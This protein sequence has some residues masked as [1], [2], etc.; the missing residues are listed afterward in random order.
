MKG[1]AATA[2]GTVYVAGTERYAPQYSPIGRAEAIGVTVVGGLIATSAAWY[3]YEKWGEQVV[4]EIAGD[5]SSDEQVHWSITSIGTTTMTTAKL[6]TEEAS[7]QLKQIKNGLYGDAKSVIIQHLNDGSSQ[8]AAVSAAQDK[9]YEHTESVERSLLENFRVLG[10]QLQTMHK[11]AV[12]AGLAGNSDGGSVD[13]RHNPDWLGYTGGTTIFQG[14][15]VASYKYTTG[16]GKEYE[17]IDLDLYISNAGDVTKTGSLLRDGGI[18]D[19]LHLKDPEGN[20][21]TW[22]HPGMEDVLSS[23]RTKRDEVLSQVATIANEI[24]SNYQ[25]GELDSVDSTYD[26]IRR[27]LNE[28]A[29]DGAAAYATA[30]EL[31]YQTNAEADYRIEY[32]ERDSSGNLSDPVTWDGVLLADT[33]TFS[34]PIKAGAT[35]DTQDLSGNVYFLFNTGSSNKTQKEQL[36][37]RFTVKQIVGDNGEQLEQVKQQNNN[38]TTRDTSNMDKQLEIINERRDA[39]DNRNSLPTNL[40]AEDGLFGGGTGLP[41]FGDIPRWV[42]AI[43]VIGGILGLFAVIA[44]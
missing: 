24:Y 15:E 26:S 3:A 29:D 37:G 10:R 44:D 19:S 5:D 39:V 35:Y 41:G 18:T 34:E 30:A 43:P 38:F 6:Q 33:G 20:Y 28:K 21:T 4:S 42:Y 36:S 9:V 12:D 1:A 22:Q 16:N 2:T 14:T 27:R 23:I 7:S 32:R 11:D 25:P 8:S 13:G 17:I 40:L 31:G